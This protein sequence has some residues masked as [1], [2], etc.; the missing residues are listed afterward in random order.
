MFHLFIDFLVFFAGCVSYLDDY[1]LIVNYPNNN[2][3]K[4]EVEEYV[5]P[6]QKPN[7]KTKI[8]FSQT[9][10]IPINSKGS[11]VNEVTI[12]PLD[13]IHLEPQFSK[14]HPPDCENLFPSYDVKPTNKAIVE[15]NRFPAG[16]FYKADNA[17]IQ[18]PLNRNLFTGNE[19][20]ELTI[21][22]LQEPITFTY[23]SF[24]YYR[25]R[26]FL[27]PL[28]SFANTNKWIA[29]SGI[30]IG[31]IFNPKPIINI[32]A[33]GI[34]FM[35][36]NSSRI[37]NTTGGNYNESIGSNYIQG[38]HNNTNHNSSKAVPQIEESIDRDNALTN[39]DFRNAV[40]STNQ[41]P[42]PVQNRL[43]CSN[44]GHNNP[45]NLNFCT[46]CGTK[47]NQPHI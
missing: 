11:F 36:Q 8:K 13:T 34:N 24:P 46:K 44:C 2:F 14:Y 19:S 28:L 3:K 5:I 33:E 12:K 42:P 40:S 38:D 26:A 15:L 37:I 17:D 47:L 23:F 25:L 18:K 21:R 6:N 43:V 32:A 39:P 1:R 45:A 30:I 16:S 4:L 20:I 22:N 7:Q 10:N 27:E 41:P 29:Y 35:S 9:N 31:I